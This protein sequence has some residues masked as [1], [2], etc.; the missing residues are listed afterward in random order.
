VEATPQNIR[1]RK[2]ILDPNERR[3]VEKGRAARG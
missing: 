2:R 1:L 3:R